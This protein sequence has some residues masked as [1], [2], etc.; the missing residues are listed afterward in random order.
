MVKFK[1]LFQEKSAVGH[2]VL[3]VLCLQLLTLTTFMEIRLPIPTRNNLNAFWQNLVHDTYV[4]IPEKYKLYIP[5]SYRQN[6]VQFQP[7]YEK[8]I[9][10]REIYTPQIPVAILVLFTLDIPFNLLAYLLFIA[11]GLIGPK[12]N[13][14]PLSSGGGLAYVYEP[15]FGYIIGIFLAGFY[16]STR[17][18]EEKFSNYLIYIFVSLFI[19]HT[20]GI[21]CLF[22]LNFFSYL[23]PINQ[24]LLNSKNIIYE[25]IRNYT[26]YQLP[27]DIVLLL[28]LFPVIKVLQKIVDIIVATDFTPPITAT[29][30]LSNKVSDMFYK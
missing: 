21:A 6:Q 14:F 27:Y 12:F 26:W 30:S 1:E 11:L 20:T 5:A 3:L 18:Q 24:S 13:I 15:G 22:G 23:P 8:L 19:I 2:F 9:V 29:K 25:L 16:I 28:L 7:N 4:L 10:R 17:K